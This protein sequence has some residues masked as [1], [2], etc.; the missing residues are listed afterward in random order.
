MADERQSHH[1][2]VEAMLDDD[3]SMHRAEDDLR[4]VAFEARL[5]QCE[6]RCAPV[7]PVSPRT[8]ALV[9]VVLVIVAAI[10]LGWGKILPGEAIAGLIG[11]LV[12]RLTSDIGSEGKAKP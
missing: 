8:L 1:D 7:D 5:R 11:A 3:R 12:G 2:L 9:C 6:A 4:M 10:A